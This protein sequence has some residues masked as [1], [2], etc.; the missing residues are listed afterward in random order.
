VPGLGIIF[1]EHRQRLLDLTAKARLPSM[2][3]RKK[4][5]EAGGLMSYGPNWGDMYRRAATYV[6]KILKGTKPADLPVEQPTKLELVINLKTAKALGLTIPAT[7]TR[8]SN[9]SRIQSEWPF[10]A[11]S[12]PTSSGTIAGVGRG[13]AKTL[14]SQ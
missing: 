6:D 3:L 5:V 7:P 1:G 2:F 9:N 12:A 10:S 4:F 8:S 11:R 13:C 14:K